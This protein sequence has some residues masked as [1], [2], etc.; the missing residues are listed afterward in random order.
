MGLVSFQFFTP[1]AYLIALCYQLLTFTLNRLMFFFK[2]CVRGF[3]VL[4][5]FDN[6]NWDKFEKLCRNGTL[7]LVFQS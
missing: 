5:D 1:T 3:A 4:R 7:Y 6:L 2:F